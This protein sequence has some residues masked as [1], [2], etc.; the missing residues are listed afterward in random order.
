MA[1][2][3]NVKFSE[4]VYEELSRIAKEQ[5]K[6]V[7]AVLRD[8]VTLEKYVA[9]TRRDGGRLLVEKADGETRELLVR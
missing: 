1:K 5:G 2:R 4:E 6:T 3:I 9:D 8:A 7:S